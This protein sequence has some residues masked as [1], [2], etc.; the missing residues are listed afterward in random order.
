LPAFRD[1]YGVDFD[2][3]TDDQARELDKRV[4]ANYRNQDWLRHVVTEKARIDLMFNDP[5]WD[6]FGFGASYPFEVLVF[7]VTTLIF[8]FHP[9]EFLN[10]SDDP[11]KFA[12]EHGMKVD[13]LDDYLHVLDALFQEAK[14]RGAACLKT[15]LAYQRTLRFE[16]VPRTRAE[17][18]FGRPRKELS[19]TELKDFEDFIMWRL[20]ELSARY[21]LPFQIHTGHGR[22]QGSSPMNLLD[23]IEANPKTKFILFH[24]GFPWV[25]ETGAIAMRHVN[26]VWIDSVWLPT[27]SP[28]LARRA[29]NVWLEMVPSNR[30]L[31][32]ADCN[33]AE[34]IYGATVVT[35]DVVAEVLAE[36][37]EREELSESDA[38]RIG[39]Q[40]LRDN[41]LALF[42]SLNA[43]LDQ[44]KASV[45]KNIKNP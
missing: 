43:R 37:V 25:D 27:L 29:L 30:I 32:G 15:T 6:R 22:L 10:P 39:R 26:H 1:L 12:G 8:G 28:T 16:N 7:N 13:S 42:P 24:G 11:Y 2:H 14:S 3:L 45:R 34:G 35:R 18:V 19:L 9:T 31:W 17:H 23:L 36:K 40:I 41:A 44:G 38:A 4:F 20:V 33:H 5:Y 21:E